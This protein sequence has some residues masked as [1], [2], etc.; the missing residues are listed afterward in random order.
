MDST[1]YTNTVLREEVRQYIEDCFKKEAVD[2]VFARED[3]AHI[4]DAMDLLNKA[5]SQM[6]ADFGAKK[7]SNNLNNAR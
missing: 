2:K 4:A 6:E 3:V 5:F 7:E 1:F